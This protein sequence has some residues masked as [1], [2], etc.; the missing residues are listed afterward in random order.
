[1]ASRV[2]YLQDVD[3]TLLDNDRVVADLMH[4]LD[5]TV[6][7]DMQQH[8]WTFFNKLR[9]ELGTQTIRGASGVPRRAAT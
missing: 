3:N 5:Q 4:H 8:Y 1:M 7:H 2:V 6:G 9:E